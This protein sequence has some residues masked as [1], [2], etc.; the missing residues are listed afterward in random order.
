MTTEQHDTPA[1]VDVA[2]LMRRQA[3]DRPGMAIYPPRRKPWYPA[4]LPAPAPLV[5]V[6][7]TDPPAARPERVRLEHADPVGAGVDRVDG[8]PWWRRRWQWWA[9]H[10]GV[11]SGG[12]AWT[13]RGGE[14]RLTRYLRPDRPV[15]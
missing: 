2:A 13:R 12:W 10:D 3:A 4:P 6:E 15:R 14:R 5:R 1:P 9:T 11:A 8:R 7:P